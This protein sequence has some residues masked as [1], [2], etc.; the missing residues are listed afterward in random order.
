MKPRTP[1]KKQKGIAER[2]TEN[3]PKKERS[4]KAVTLGLLLW[5][6]TTW[7]FYGSGIVRHIDQAKGGGANYTKAGKKAYTIAAA[8][9]KESLEEGW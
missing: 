1:R 2:K 3:G 8:R 4:Y 6:F 7:L 5:L 9:L